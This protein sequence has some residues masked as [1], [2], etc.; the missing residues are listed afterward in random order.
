MT[1][2][3]SDP[4]KYPPPPPVYFTF[5]SFR[6]SGLKKSVPTADHLH[7]KKSELHQQPILGR[8]RQ[9]LPELD[10]LVTATSNFVIVYGSADFDENRR[11]LG[12]EEGRRR[13][14]KKKKI[15][16]P[17]NRFYRFLNVFVFP[18]CFHTHFSISQFFIQF[19]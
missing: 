3:I 13:E 12:D 14:P 18:F 4:I 2:F 8:G 10:V 16:T 7:P 9:S 19:R 17:R 5:S 6:F 1:K 11:A 15:I